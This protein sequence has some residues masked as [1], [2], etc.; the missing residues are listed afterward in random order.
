MTSQFPV[1]VMVSHAAVVPGFRG[2]YTL[3]QSYK[4]VNQFEY[5]S[6][7]VC[8]HYCSVEHGLVR[9]VHYLLIVF[10]Y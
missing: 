4:A 10:V 5:R 8:R 3:L 9:V 6:R 2:Y 1:A 7:R